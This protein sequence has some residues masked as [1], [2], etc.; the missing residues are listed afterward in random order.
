MQDIIAA[1]LKMTRNK[2]KLES[3]TNNTYILEGGNWIYSITRDYKVQKAKIFDNKNTIQITFESYNNKYHLP[4]KVSIKSDSREF[5]EAIISYSKV[6]V[7]KSQ[8]VLFEI[9]KSYNE[10]K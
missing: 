3:D 1:N 5:F 2:Y 9:P 4:R 8:K 7:N 6:E 10:T